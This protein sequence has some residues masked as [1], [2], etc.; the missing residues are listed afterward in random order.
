MG[1][2]E[3]GQPPTL[4]W[5]ERR[6]PAR[7]REVRA[8]LFKSIKG[9]LGEETYEFVHAAI[10]VAFES[11]TRTEDASTHE[12]WYWQ[13]RR[14]IEHQQ[15]EIAEDDLVRACPGMESLVFYAPD[16]VNCQHRRR[17]KRCV[18]IREK[19][20]LLLH[21][22][23][24]LH[25]VK[26]APENP[27]Q[28][29]P[30]RVGIERRISEIPG[31]IQRLDDSVDVA[32]ATPSQFCSSTVSSDVV[33]PQERPGFGD[34]IRRQADPGR[35]HDDLQDYLLETIGQHLHEKGFSRRE[36]SRCVAEILV[37][38]FGRGASSPDP[39]AAMENM[40]ESVERHWR[41][42]RHSG[43]QAER[44]GEQRPEQRTEPHSY[45]PERL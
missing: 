42:L 32:S 44:K 22:K 17:T 3:T 36:A 2:S 5:I 28:V 30:L 23:R 34:P 12:D 27:L 18:T 7:H 16:E 11:R 26:L 13:R 21:L 15:E 1:G 20:E 35:P 39:A 37:Y 8:A 45:G 10:R 25:T 43:D 6:A 38:C 31:E 14:S 4:E 9:R 19:L 29:N 40:V 41:V 24:L 33:D